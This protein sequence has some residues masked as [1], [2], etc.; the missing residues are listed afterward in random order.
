MSSEKM[1]ILEMVEKKTISV[2]EGLKLLNALEKL[3]SSTVLSEAS[4]ESI[5]ENINEALESAEEDRAEALEE[6]SEELE[7]IVEDL[8]EEIDEMVEEIE[9]AYDDVTDNMDEDAKEALHEKVDEIRSKAEEIKEKVKVNVNI[10]GQ[11]FKKEFYT[12]DFKNIF[13]NDLKKE[14]EGLKKSFKGDLKSFSKEAKRFGEE[15]SKLG[16]ETANIT[17]DVV[18]E[19]FSVLN[20]VDL[21]GQA[22]FSEDE[23][24]MDPDTEVRNYNLAQEF[25]ID[26]DGKKDV[27]INVISTDV[28]IV[29]EERDDILV[30]YI[31]YN[32]ADE[33]RFVVVVEED[34]KKVKITEKSDAKK[35]RMFNFQSGGRELLVRLPRKYKESLSVK[36]VSGDLDLNYLDSDFFRFT[37]VSGDVTA[38][39][40]YSVNSLVKTTSGDCEIGLFRGSMMFSSV[41]GDLQMKY[42]HL[43]G[44]MTAKTVSG[45]LDVVLP[46]NSEFEVMAKS[47]SGS[48][49]CDFPMT[50]I[51]TQ[52]RGRMRGQVGSDANKVTAST[53]SGSL[54]LIRY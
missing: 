5:Q 28:N 8:E 48:M 30:N 23:F 49:T 1:K 11:K 42:E 6:L 24:Q 51:G 34:S 15:M 14:F 40:V 25:S 54:H 26:C 32:P 9:D 10:N 41:S 52:K 18:D 53:T 47:V 19:A 20:E 27:A 33:G 38:D 35:K 2:D 16:R 22:E 12:D 46:K 37:S 29:T 45:D 3:E 50:V 17:K 43:D 31:K 39:I 4:K 36:T 44:D 13:H 21:T 7:E